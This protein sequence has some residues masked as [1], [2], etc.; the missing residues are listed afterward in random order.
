M[1]TAS[2]GNCAISG[3]TLNTW[4]KSQTSDKTYQRWEMRTFANTPQISPAPPSADFGSPARQCRMRLRRALGRTRRKE[5]RAIPMAVH[6]K[7]R[8][9]LFSR[10]LRSPRRPSLRPEIPFPAKSLSPLY[11]FT[12]GGIYRRGLPS[13]TPGAALGLLW[14]PRRRVGG[15]SP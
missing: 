5:R 14:R 4:L 12:K 11:F 7:K 3:E 1:K 6:K 13:A 10:N 15:S 2:R 8:A 9:L